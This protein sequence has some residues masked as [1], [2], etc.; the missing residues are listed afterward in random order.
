MLKRKSAPDPDAEVKEQ[1]ARKKAAATD[2]LTGLPNRG[3]LLP[4][5]S[6]LIQ[7][8]QATSE[9]MS[10]MFVSIN[11]ISD[12]ND[13][14]GPDSGDSLLRLVGERLAN[15]LGPGQR[16]ARYVGAEF[17]IVT[18]RVGTADRAAD[19]A[20][21][22]FEAL[23]APFPMGSGEVTVGG[24]IGIALSDAGY[25]DAKAWLDDA[26]DAVAEAREVA[27]TSRSTK[28]GCKR[29]S[30]TTS[31]GWCTNRSSFPPTDGSSGS[32]RYFVGSTPAAAS[33]SSHPDTSFL[34]SKRPGSSHRSA[35]G[36]S[37]SPYAKSRAGTT[38]E[39]IRTPSS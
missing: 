28:T 11:H 16:I 32:R 8:E 23:G 39:A 7:K 20:D 3:N 4:W 5:L 21:E 22:V 26:H 38:R 10:L 36:P 9:R 2:P 1:A 14:F 31:S 25:P 6:R 27:S 24:S 12:V 17:A 29:H 30:R 33:G 13:T 19:I 15:S 35:P 18:E 37:S 34:S